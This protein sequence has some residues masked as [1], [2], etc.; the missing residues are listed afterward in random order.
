MGHRGFGLLGLLLL[1]FNFV[2]HGLDEC[3]ELLFALLDKLGFGFVLL[4][5]HHSE[6]GQ[7]AFLWSPDLEEGVGVGNRGFALL[8]EVEILHDGGLIAV[9]NDGI[10]PTPITDVSMM[11]GES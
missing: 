11:D 5:G 7:R 6:N 1:V 4:I 10:N 8:A 2:F 3:V 9:T